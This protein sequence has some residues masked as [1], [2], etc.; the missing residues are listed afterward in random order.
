MQA[1]AVNKQIQ[2]ANLKRLIADLET[3]QGNGTSMISLYVPTN[4]L[5]RVS[6]QL[7]EEYAISASIKSRV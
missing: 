1:D 5:T 7:K 6:K 2:Q 4:A 3:A